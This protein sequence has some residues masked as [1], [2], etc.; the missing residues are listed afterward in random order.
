MAKPQR[1]RTERGP[2]VFVVDD[3]AMIRESLV[4]L[5][6]AEGIEVQAYP[7]ANHFLDD[8]QPDA[9]G[10]L[11]LE[12]DMPGICG[13]KL[14]ELL[15]E[16]QLHIP[17]IILTGQADVPKTIQAFKKGVFDF[18]EKPVSAETLLER[19]NSA[20][21]KNARERSE[22]LIRTSIWERF[23]HLTP[24]EREVMSLLISGHSNKQMAQRLDISFRTVEV[25]RRRVYEKTGA[26]SLA[27]LISMEAFIQKNNLGD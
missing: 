20:F 14:Q 2:T 26:V 3:D 6:E 9:S 16:R 17:I 1:M 10:C 5:L 24:R 13:L 22:A 27:N 8:F 11:L 19:I 25:H 23:Q 21:T 12:I 7:S 15:L 18:L 4:A